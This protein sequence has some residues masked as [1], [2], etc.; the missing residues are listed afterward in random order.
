MTQQALIVT[1]CFEESV[2]Q[3]G[4]PHGVEMAGG[5]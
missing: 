3:H 1:T 2:G 5:E 4:E